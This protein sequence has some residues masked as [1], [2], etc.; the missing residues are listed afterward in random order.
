M[1]YLIWKLL[2]R[3][4][5]EDAADQAIELR[6]MEKHIID[7]FADIDDDITLIPL[8]NSDD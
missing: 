5:S 7:G 4:S 6:S 3:D 1:G 2:K 8:I